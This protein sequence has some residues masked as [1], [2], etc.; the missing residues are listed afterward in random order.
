M[1]L[2]GRKKQNTFYGQTGSVWEWKQGVIKCRRDGVERKS[3]ERDGWN[4]GSFGEQ[5]GNLMQWKLSE[6]SEGDPSD[7]CQ[8]WKIWSPHWP[9]FVASQGSQCWIRVTFGGVVAL[10]YP[11]EIPKQPRLIIVWKDTP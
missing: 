10:G 1:G 2:P 7:D 6:I 11:V 3:S 8:V 4:W 5:Y 9:S